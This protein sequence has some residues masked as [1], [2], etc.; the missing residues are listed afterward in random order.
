MRV[1]T[2]NLENLDET[3]TP[4]LEQ[5]IAVLRPQ[6]IRLNADILCLQEINGQERLGQKRQLLALQALLTD[7]PYAGYYMATT[8]TS[9]QEPYDVRNLVT[10]S[11]YPFLASRQVKNEYVGDLLYRRITAQPQEQDAKEI[12]W[13]RPILHVK[14]GHPQG[15]IDVIN[16]HLKSRLPTAIPGQQQGFGFKTVEGWAEGYFISS[17]K[18]VGQALEVR[19]MI[20]EILDNDPSARIIVCGDFNS[21]PGDVPVEAI[22]G[23]IENTGNAALGFRQLIPCSNSIPKEVR[24]SH[25]HEGR[26]NLLDHMLISRTL[27]AHYRSAEIHNEILHDESIA[28]ASDVKYPESDHAPFVVSFDLQETC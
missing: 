20:D 16:I 19:F 2:F 27:L 3:S 17:M 24:H 26:G 9:K 28:F 21:E 5:R 25:L 18:R 1:A 15:P 7:T 11:K 10:L 14:I 23:R 22:A 8:L 12:S 4:S 6:L 13:E